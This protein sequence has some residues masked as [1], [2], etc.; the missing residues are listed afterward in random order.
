M[1][2]KVT[3]KGVLRQTKGFTLT[4]VMVGLVMFCAALGGLVPVI[5]VSRTFALQ[6]DSRV[7]AIAVAQQLMDT[8]RQVDVSSL[9]NSG[10]AT[11]LPSGDL[12]TALPYKG[13]TYSATITYCEVAAHCDST[14]RHLKVKVYQ[15][16]NTSTTPVRSPDVPV[17]QL[18]TIYG[19]LQ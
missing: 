5:M 15:D 16:G 14:T 11:T 2:I 18:E 19:R 8:L 10:T 13:K 7:G 1:T 6:S 12:I 4:E 9:P 17:F 3:G